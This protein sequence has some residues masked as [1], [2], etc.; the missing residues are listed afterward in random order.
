MEEFLESIEG[1]AYRMAFAACGHREDALDMVQDAM[2]RFVDKYATRP[3]EEWKPLFYRIL[4][5]RITDNHRRRAVRDKWNGFIGTFRDA[6]EDPQSD[7][8]QTVPDRDGKTPEQSAQVGGA[9][10]ALQAALIELPVRQ[11]Q[12]FMLR[13]WEELSVKETARAM[14]CSEGSVKTHFSRA[15][16]ALRDRLGDHWP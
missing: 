6:H 15:V 9:F 16:K 3:R 7:P 14:N 5:N 2:F 8:F 13:A 1:R 4:Q 12:V 10:E 11:R